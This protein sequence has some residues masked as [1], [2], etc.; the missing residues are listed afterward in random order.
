MFSYHLNKKHIFE[1]LDFTH[2]WIVHVQKTQRCSSIMY[3]V[4]M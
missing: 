4:D 2:A 3:Y 1:Q